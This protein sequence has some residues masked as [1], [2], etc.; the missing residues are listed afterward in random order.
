[1]T[2]NEPAMSGTRSEPGDEL[3]ELSDLKK[4]LETERARA[5]SNLAGW[6]RAQADFSNYR[7]RVEQEKSDQAKY[8]SAPV[9]SQTLTVLDDLERALAAV[10]AA[11]A[12]MTWIDGVYLIYR[13]LLAILEAQGVREVSAQDQAFDPQLHEAVLHGAGPEGRVIQVLQKGYYL[14][15]RVLRPAMVVVGNGANTEKAATTDTETGPSSSG[16]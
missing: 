15:D 2:T 14:H 3:K 16:G 4:T 7:R 8:A 13:K 6:Q 9:L 1:M 10:P 12:Q 11:L 5:E